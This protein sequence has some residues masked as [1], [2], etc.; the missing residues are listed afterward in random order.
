MQRRQGS[1]ALWS[2]SCPL[3]EA[4]ATPFMAYSCSSLYLS[5][6]MS[7]DRSSAAAPKATSDV[8][9]CRRVQ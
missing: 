2:S 6:L 8:S 4:G 5:C 1:T 9:S 7:R 3:Y